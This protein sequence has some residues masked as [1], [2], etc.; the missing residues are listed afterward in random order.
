MGKAADLSEFD[1]GQIL[2]ARRL[3]TS[4]TETARLAGCSRSAVVSIHAKWINDGDTSSTGQGVGRP[5]VIKEKGRRRLSE[6][7]HYDHLVK[8][9]RCQTVDQLTAQYNVGP[10]ACVSEHTVQR[11]L[12]DMGLCSRRLSRVPLL[13]KRHRQLR[14]QWAR[15]HRNWTMDEWARVAS[16]D[17]S[18][19]LIHDV[20]GRV[21]VRR[22]PGEQ[23]FPS[24]T[25]GH[26]QA[27]GGGIMLWGTF[28][29]AALGPI[30]VV[31]QTM[32]AANYLNIIADQ[33]HPYM[34]FVFPTGNGIF[35]QDSVRIVLEWFEEHTYEF[36]LMSRPPNSPDLN[37]MEMGCHGEAAQSSNTTMSEYLDFAWPLLRHLVQPVS[38][39]VPKTCGIYAQASCSCFE[40]QRRL[41]ALLNRWS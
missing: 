40:G 12:L 14:L 4:I 32:K 28:S 18:R 37:P 33:L 10:S 36:H 35:Q 41:N 31:E 9:N 25:A 2:M 23:L 11:T 27:G 30:V 6:P 13:T 22:L 5:R 24:C 17:E 7:K 1:R 16:S 19:F 20:D 15:E 3:G 21:R 39:H 29:W 26:T 38:S 8:Q 34:A